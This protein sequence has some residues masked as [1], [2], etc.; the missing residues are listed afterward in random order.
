MRDATLLETLAEGFS[1]PFVL[2][3]ALAGGLLGWSTRPPAPPPVR[4]PA[5][6]PV[7]ATEKAPP[8]ES[9]LPGRPATEADVRALVAQGDLDRAARWAE[10]SGL[11]PLAEEV[12]LL[13][14]LAR[15]A[16][17]GPLAKGPLVRV[18]MLDNAVHLGV[19]QEETPT[20][21]KLQLRDATA[22]ALERAAIRE[23]TPLEGD[24]ARRALDALFQA[25]RAALGARPGGLAL[26]RLAF[27]ALA[28]G[29][30]G[31][32]ATALREA[33]ASPEGTIIVELF[34]EGDLPRLQRAR[35]RLTGGP[36]GP[37]TG[38]EVAA[39][40]TEAPPP[41]PRT[42]PAPPPRTEP[43]PPPRT[44]AAPPPATEEEPPPDEPPPD[45]PPPPARS[46]SDDLFGHPSWI[47]AEAAWRSGLDSYRR[48][49]GDSIEVAA[50][51]VKL[52]L[53]QFR[54]AQDL[55]DR[56][57]RDRPDLAET[58]ELERRQQELN[59]LVL[60]CTKRLGTH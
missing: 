3:A 44:E 28:A 27:Q 36:S 16:K 15:G 14:N 38:T 6:P 2:L 29:A 13:E 18:T 31:A 12:R 23:R 60:D 45:E 26:H 35:E 59:S 49:F 51:S 48:S 40:R 37:A 30:R 50:P 19:V 34:G 9:D 58:Y 7:A 17:P 25:D 57:T 11:G 1:L 22:V 33:L 4:P 56:L 53:R 21:L 24:A 47:A 55:L 10:A 8:P 54:L 32:G 5:P 43:A 20:T 42:E 46:T 52:A 41:R 39:A